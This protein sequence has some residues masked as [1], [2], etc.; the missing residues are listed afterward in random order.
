M[1]GLNRPPFHPSGTLRALVAEPLELS[2]FTAGHSSNSF[3]TLITKGQP[4]PKYTRTVDSTVELPDLGKS[5][6]FGEVVELPKDFFVDADH[7]LASGFTPVTAVSP[8]E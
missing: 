2:A 7:A 5:V 6:S 8:K 1:R 4:M 3:F